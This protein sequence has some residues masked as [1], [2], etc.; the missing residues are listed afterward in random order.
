MGALD[1]VLD[2][3]DL[4]KITEMEEG[5]RV[6]NPRLWFEPEYGWLDISDFD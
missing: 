4:Q 2:G 5:Y 1:V 6:F 3:D